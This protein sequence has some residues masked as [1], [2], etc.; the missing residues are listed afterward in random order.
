LLLIENVILIE[1]YYHF[2]N[3][4]IAI[5]RF[6][7]SSLILNEADDKI[8][9]RFIMSFHEIKTIQLNY[10]D[11]KIVETQWMHQVYAKYVHH[12]HIDM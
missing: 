1:R 6:T 4:L 11:E 12:C 9:L 2:M 3:E 7:I 10:R 8:S 5:R